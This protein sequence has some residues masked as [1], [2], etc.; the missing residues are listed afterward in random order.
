DQA[1]PF[2][3]RLHRGRSVP[4]QP[5]SGTNPHRQSSAAYLHPP[6]PFRGPS[7]PRDRRHHR[8]P[9]SGRATAS[10]LVP[11]SGPWL[12]SLPPSGPFSPPLRPSDG[13]SRSWGPVRPPD[14]RR[15]RSTRASST[16]SSPRRTRSRIARRVPAGPSTGP[17]GGGPPV[18][19]GYAPAR[20][21]AGVSPADIS[22][23]DQP[24]PGSEADT[25]PPRAA[26][27]SSSFLR[28]VG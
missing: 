28:T 19:A 7:P 22:L 2:L 26:M 11:P 5:V 21:P 25:G 14:P 4:G 23:P 24:A 20:P 12:P 17:T 3:L 16:V 13:L 6:D 8:F 1:V 15:P 10:P 27:I 18:A 9:S